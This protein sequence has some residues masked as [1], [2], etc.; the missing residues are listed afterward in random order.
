MAASQTSR[1]RLPS[2]RKFDLT[3]ISKWYLQGWS[4]YKIAD[5]LNSLRP[6]S[7]SRRTITNDIKAVRKSW[8]KESVM[9]F[10]ERVAQELAKLDNVEAKAW[11]GWERSDNRETSV[12]KSVQGDKTFLE[13]T[14]TKVGQAGDP[15]F[16]SIITKC[17]EQRCRLLGVDAAINVDLTSG[18]EKL[19]ISEVYY[20]TDAESENKDNKSE[21]E[22]IN[23]MKANDR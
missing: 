5:E 8:L 7:V 6:Y 15:R 18:G 3:I 17:I 16:L 9:N 2:E 22:K 10:D 13:A 4:H 23:L 12:R 14:L 11:E 1:K 19:V 20:T 21:S